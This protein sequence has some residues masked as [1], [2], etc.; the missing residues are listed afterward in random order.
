[1]LLAVGTFTALTLASFM[2]YPTLALAVLLAPATVTVLALWLFALGRSNRNS[3]GERFRCALTW[4]VGG[5]L[6]ADAWVL[7]LSSAPIWNG[8]FWALIGQIGQDSDS[9]F[10]GL[11]V[12]GYV[13]AVATG[14]ALIWLNLIAER[15]AR[16]SARHS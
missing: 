12:V 11:A 4:L 7:A 6:C 13:I 15:R 10:V 8:S 9:T 14:T 5:W 16:R 2:S 3:S 1:V